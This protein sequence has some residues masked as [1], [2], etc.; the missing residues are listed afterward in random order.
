ML[1]LGK[2]SLS[3]DG[4]VKSVNNARKWF[5]KAA[6]RGNDEAARLLETL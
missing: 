4:M 1:R 6:V 2:M 3:G 5:Q